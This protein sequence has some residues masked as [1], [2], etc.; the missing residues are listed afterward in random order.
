MARK[1]KTDEAKVFNEAT[2]APPVDAE[3]RL[4]SLMEKHD[5][6]GLTPPAVEGTGVQSE[7]PPET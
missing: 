3:S 6:L 2:S 1:L 4:R 5:P 7:P